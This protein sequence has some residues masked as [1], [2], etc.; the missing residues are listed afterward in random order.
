[1]SKLYD[2]DLDFLRQ[3]SDEDLAPL[4][5]IL[6]DPISETL[7]V[8]EKYKVHNPKHGKYIDE[9]IN[10][11][12]GFG[13]NTIFNILR[14][15][16]VLYR[17]ILLDV[18]KKLKMKNIQYYKSLPIDEVEFM[19]IEE[20]L[21]V[22]LEKLS[23]GERAA[24][25]SDLGL[26]SKNSTNITTDVV[27]MSVRQAIQKG[28]F[29][30]YKIILKIVN[31]VWNATFGLIFG[32]LSL[33]TNALIVKTTKIIASTPVAVAMG[34][35]TIFDIA[36]PAYRVTVPAVYCIASLRLRYKYENL[37]EQDK[38]FMEIENS[39]K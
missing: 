8:N 21:R 1:M 28:G 27:I 19:L 25:L 15:H 2:A 4:V 32:G 10:E 39:K 34:I 16:G 30:S 36:S 3:I 12:H 6:T 33:S 37:I 13:G 7:T 24:F 35:W 5:K 17:E 26:E 29:T 9:I 18:C 20:G 22:K 31:F 38:E 23:E 11:I 14:G